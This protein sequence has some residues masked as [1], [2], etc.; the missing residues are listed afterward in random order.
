MIQELSRGNNYLDR[1][2]LQRFDSNHSNNEQSQF[3]VGTH[4][5][6]GTGLDMMTGDTSGKCNESAMKRKAGTLSGNTGRS[7]RAGTPLGTM[8]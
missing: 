4:R 2:R 6:F 8:N 1:Y 3:K 5:G 7:T